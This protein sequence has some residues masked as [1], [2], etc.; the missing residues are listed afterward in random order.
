[1]PYR[2][3]LA[4]KNAK[5]H[6]KPSFT[7]M[8]ADDDPHICLLVKH[9]LTARGFKVVSARDG[10]EAIGLAQAWDLDLALIDLNM[11]GTDGLEAIK[12]LHMSEPDLPI[13]VI[14]GETDGARR[15]RA[16]EWGG[17]LIL[18]K[19]LR[20]DG[21]MEGIN[22]LLNISIDAALATE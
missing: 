1:M 2:I 16:R 7:V 12:V 22:Q 17:H 19:P 9:A 5:G 14:T 20:L 21:L 8:V 11:P 6:S 18:N 15:R 4:G 13:M 3:N 10:A